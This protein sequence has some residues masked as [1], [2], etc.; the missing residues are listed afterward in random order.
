MPQQEMNY[1]GAN[2]EERSGFYQHPF[3]QSGQKVYPH[4]VGREVALR[5]RAWVAYV[6]LA[7]VMVAS[8][9]YAYFGVAFNG[10]QNA[11]GGT[12]VTDDVR[13]LSAVYLVIIGVNVVVNIFI[14]K[15]YRR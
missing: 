1:E 13:I 4:Y 8:F 5:I 10:G 2:R 7:L 15:K 11:P 6:S 9:I 14:A 12:Q 3:G